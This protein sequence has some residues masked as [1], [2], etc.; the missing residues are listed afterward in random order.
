MTT[1]EHLALQQLRQQL[2]QQQIQMIAKA[3][4]YEQLAAGAPNGQ[5][6][7]P[8]T[9]SGLNCAIEPDPLN[10]YKD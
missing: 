7:S 4:M 10:I 3:V 5:V 6:D 2:Q 9:A 1:I 8:M